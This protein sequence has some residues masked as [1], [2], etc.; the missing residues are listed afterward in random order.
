MAEGIRRK[1][2]EGP[3]GSP[4]EKRDPVGSVG[5]HR[6]IDI[7]QFGAWREYPCENP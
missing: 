3:H 1:E 7:G 4:L 5:L 2:E 6:A